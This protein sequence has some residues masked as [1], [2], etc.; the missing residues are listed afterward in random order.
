MSSVGEA[1][2]SPGLDD[3]AIKSAG[4]V[5]DPLGLGQKHPSHQQGAKIADVGDL[6][7]VRLV[8]PSDKEAGE[9]L[10]LRKTDRKRLPAASV[11]YE[12]KKGELRSIEADSPLCEMIEMCRYDLSKRSKI[13]V[14]GENDAV[15][16]EPELLG[17]L[18][19]NT[20]DLALI[21][22]VN[23]QK[24]AIGKPTQA[25]LYPMVFSRRTRCFVLIFFARAPPLKCL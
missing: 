19:K 23:F 7:E 21:Q 4:L 3:G 13:F 25:R 22:G 20:A 12:T 8:P 17:D 24:G 14:M 11:L 15:P 16:E 2:R 1:S 5:D 6:A 18:V 10:I 9:I